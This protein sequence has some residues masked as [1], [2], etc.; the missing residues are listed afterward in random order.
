MSDI[1]HSGGGS[2]RTRIS[3][4]NNPGCIAKNPDKKVAGKEVLDTTVAENTL[5]QLRLS[6]AAA[7]QTQT[8]PGRRYSIADPT[9]GADYFL[10][11]DTVNH[12]SC[13]PGQW[14][15]ATAKAAPGI[16]LP[17]RLRFSSDE[18]NIDSA[19]KAAFKTTKPA[20]IT[21]TNDTSAGK[22]QTI[23]LIGALGYP[24]PL[25]FD[26]IPTYLDYFS[27][28]II[29]YVSA[30]QTITKK[31]SMPSSYSATSYT[32]A[33]TVF[34]EEV[35]FNSMPGVTHVLTASPQYLWNARD[36]SK[37]FS[38]KANYAPWSVNAAG[39]PSSTPT[40]NKPFEPDGVLGDS[41]LALLF[42][43]RYDQG[44]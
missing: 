16:S 17:I 10:G 1:D 5:K 4:A 9:I 24:I 32:A 41:T 15:Q 11:A 13:V 8:A 12:I 31:Q 6:F 29:P 19:D 30:N 3:R 20:K 27:G 34:D 7:L 22:T 28:Q 18:L 21:Y 36:R 35:I 40:I 25:K 2:T 26:Q 38:V 23:T 42:D 33:G 43:L 39:M 37:I 14:P 44:Y